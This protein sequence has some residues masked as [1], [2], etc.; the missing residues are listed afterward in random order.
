[1]SFKPIQINTFTG[2]VDAL[3]RTEGRFSFVTMVLTAPAN[4]VA[5]FIVA[6]DRFDGVVKNIMV[7]LTNLDSP[8]SFP[9]FFRLHSQ[10]EGFGHCFP[11]EL[12]IPIVE[13]PNTEQ[14]VFINTGQFHAQ[15]ILIQ[16]DGFVT[17]GQLRLNFMVE[18][19]R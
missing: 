18:R 1:M 12:I 8:P 10:S 3:M 4:F 7:D 2:S 15:N 17:G 9:T 6:D 11:P 13:I 16:V 14:Q 19:P 5:F